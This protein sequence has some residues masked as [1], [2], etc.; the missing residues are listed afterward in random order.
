[1]NPSRRGASALLSFASD[2]AVDPVATYREHGFAVVR[3]VFA[4]NEV[5]ELAAAFDEIYAQGLAYGTSY[6]HQNVLFRLA[7]DPRLGRV[8]RLVQWPSYFHDILDRFRR[9][10]RLVEILA[11]LIGRDLKQ[12]INQLHWK[13]PGA[14]KGEFGYH[15]D[16]R[17]RRPRNAFRDLPRSYVQT[18]IAIDPHRP[19][20]GCMRLVPGSH[21]LGELPLGECGPILGQE[22]SEDELRRLGIDPACLVDLVLDP[23]D[24][25][26]WHLHT[27]HGSGPNRSTGDRRLYLNGYVAAPNADRGAWTFRG[28]KPCPL[29]E[30]VLIHYEDLHSRP[31]PYYLE[32]G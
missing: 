30:P 8:V 25:A 6:R 21:R 24:V 29:G 32:P 10:R 31:G 15:Q 18:G 2:L 3:G 27:V 19:E 12:I 11:P 26:L 4:A 9:D 14:A 23:G 13:P 22:A 16:I 20:N 1:M 28:G 17:F 7:D 5:A